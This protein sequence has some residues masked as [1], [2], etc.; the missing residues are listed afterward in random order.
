MKKETLGQVFQRYRQVEDL[1]I[2]QIEKETKISHKMIKALENDD[3]SSLPDDLYAKHLI[4][5]YAKYLSLDYNKLLNL[6]EQGKIQSYINKKKP[7]EKKLRI[8]LTPKMVRIGLVVIIILALGTY[9]GFQVN[10]IFSPPELVIYNPANDAKISENFIEIK[11]QTEEEARVFI[12][13]KEIFLDSQGLFKTT[14]D[15]QKGINYIK[16]SAVKKHSRPNTIFRQVL[17]NN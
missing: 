8:Y 9:L 5:A 3:Y 2:E 15:L 11:G 10:K 4:K 14:I 7:K 16:I 6:Y 12:N 1:T 13:E 17:V